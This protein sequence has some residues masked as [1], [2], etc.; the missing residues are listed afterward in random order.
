ME[1]EQHNDICAVAVSMGI[2]AP[3][4]HSLTRDDKDDQRDNGSPVLYLVGVYLA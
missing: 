4:E 1:G 2:E 3:R